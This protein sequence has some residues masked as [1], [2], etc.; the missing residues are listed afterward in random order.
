[1]SHYAS[2]DQEH[3][4]QGTI[5][6]SPQSH[7]PPYQAAGDVADPD[8]VAVVVDVDAAAAAVVVVVVVVLDTV[9]SFAPTPAFLQL[10]ATPAKITTV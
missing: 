9:Q 10:S 4:N 5:C 2:A 3:L 8:A 1:M 7:S 6:G